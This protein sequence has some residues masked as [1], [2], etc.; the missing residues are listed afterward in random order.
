VSRRLGLAVVS[1]AVAPLLLAGCGSHS[2]SATAS[3]RAAH[4]MA[5][6]EVMSGTSMSAAPSAGTM[7]ADHGQGAAAPSATARLTCGTEIRAAVRRNLDLPKSPVGLHAW[8]HRLYS[9]TYRLAGGELR[10]S[11]KDLDRAAPGRAYFEGLKSRLQGAAE[12]R[13]LENFGFPAFETPQG[14]VVFIKDHKTLWVDA[15]RLTR[16]DLPADTS[17]QAIAYGVAA[18]VIGCWTE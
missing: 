1:L 9:C 12:I 11:V 18:A 14:D 2:S 7:R 4:T 3:P 15:T 16:S 5:D 6:G 13:G 8:H 10:L 17:R